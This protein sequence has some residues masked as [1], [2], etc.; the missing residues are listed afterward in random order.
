V[1][2]AALGK[3]FSVVMAPT[4]KGYFAECQTQHSAKS[5]FIFKKKN[6]AECPCPKHS[7]KCFFY[8]FFK[9][10]LPSAPV[11]ALGK[12]LLIFKKNIYFFECRGKAL[13]KEIL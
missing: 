13:G 6:F 11:Q 1:F 12:E 3:I 7:A 5:I 8:Y 2:G 9:N 10:S 4:V